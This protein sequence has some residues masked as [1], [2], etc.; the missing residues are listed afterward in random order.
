MLLGRDH[1][2]SVTVGVAAAGGQ[3]PVA[4]RRDLVHSALSMGFPSD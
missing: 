1:V 2:R 3:R 4:V